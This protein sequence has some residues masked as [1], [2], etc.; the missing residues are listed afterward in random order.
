MHLTPTTWIR[1]TEE[2]NY[3]HLDLDNLSGA[4][5]EQIYKNTFPV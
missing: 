2:S 1:A 3:T 5:N 4:P